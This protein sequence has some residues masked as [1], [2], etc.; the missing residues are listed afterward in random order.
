MKKINSIIFLFIV[1]LSSNLL[2]QTTKY[3]FL[4]KDAMVFGFGGTYPKLLSTD[5]NVEPLLENYGGFLSIQKN[6]SEH[7]GLRFKGGYYFLTGQNYPKSLGTFEN[8]MIAGDIDL[9]YYFVPCEPISPYFT[10]GFGAAYF[11]LKN[12]ISRDLIDK[13][14]FDYMLNFGMGAEWKVGDDWKLKTELIHTTMPNSKIDGKYDAGNSL[15][16]GSN[17]SWMRFDLGLLYY[18]NKGEPSKFC[19]LY[20]GVNANIDYDRIEEIVRR[21]RTEPAFIDYNRIEELIKKHSRQQV[22]IEEKWVLIGVNFDFNKATLRPE[23]YPILNNAVEILL[24]NKDV[25]VEI[26]GH[27]DQIGSDKYNDQLSLKRAEAVKKYLVAKGVEPTRL[28]TVGKGK[29]N[30]LFKEMDEQSR[31]YNRRIEFHVK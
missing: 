23:A 19:Q 14:V 13:S 11:T 24:K 17:D 10:I 5:T 15:L 21:Y 29:R 6:F 22:Q 9:L 3:G 8:S 2:A 20:E 31:F 1:V 26:Q 4:A 18:F 16:G 12:P 7:I 28:T 27:T 25:K 30:L